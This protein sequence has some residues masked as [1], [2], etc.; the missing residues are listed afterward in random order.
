MKILF[1]LLA[2]C[3]FSVHSF[4][5]I[6]DAHREQ[7]F[8]EDIREDTSVTLVFQVT[9]G[10]LLDID[11]T[12]HSPSGDLLFNGNREKASRYSFKTGNTGTYKFCFSNRIST[13][14][15]KTVSWTL[16]IGGVDA[17]A[18]ATPETVSDLELNVR[19]IS[20]V[21]ANVESQQRYLRGR[22]RT[23]R[24]TAEDTNSRIMW[25]SIVELMLYVV[26][27]G[28]QIFAIRIFFDSKPSF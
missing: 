5:I 3:A 26:L 27:C 2:I 12:I 24:N 25:W 4:S 28:S 9:A 19:R 7:C 8:Y 16:D 14:A 18:V 1:F 20:D 22:E 21:L 10:G 13:F 11:A 23:H 17:K 6:L 15:A